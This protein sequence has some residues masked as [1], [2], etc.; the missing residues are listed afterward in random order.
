VLE[1]QVIDL[2]L[3]RGQSKTSKMSFDEF[4]KMQDTD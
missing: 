1:D 4:M 3:E 2:L